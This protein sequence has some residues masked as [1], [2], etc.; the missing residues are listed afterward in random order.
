MTNSLADVENNLGLYMNFYNNAD[1]FGKFINTASAA[2]YD[3][4][5][6]I[7][8]AEEEEIWHRLPKDC[9]GLSQNLRSRLSWSND[10]FY[11]LRI[12]NCFGSGEIA[13][14]IFPKF[15]ANFDK[16]CFITDNRYFDYFSI[17]DL[18]SVVDYYLENE[19]PDLARD[20]NCVYNDKYLI[21]EVIEKFKQLHSIDKEIIIKSSSENN[22]TGSADKLNK[23][24][25]QLK[26][27]HQGLKNYL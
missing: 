5:R 20:I 1:L 4:S 11:N 18:C 21:S 16:Q 2:E 7:N 24:N 22:Y 12:F 26:G 8:L 17:T 3:R 19:V 10:K 9:Y 14:R 23:L 27:L 13:T 25:I 6:N 15:L